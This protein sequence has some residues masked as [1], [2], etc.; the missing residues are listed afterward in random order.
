M[1]KFLSFFAMAAMATAA[2]ADGTITLPNGLRI[3]VDDTFKTGYI[4][5]SDVSGDLVIP[6]TVTDNGKEY[7]ITDIDSYAFRNQSG[8]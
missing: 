7:K 1:K 4:L 2:W 6:A 5:S 8:L 3:Y